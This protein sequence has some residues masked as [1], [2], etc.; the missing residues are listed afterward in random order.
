MSLVRAARVIANRRQSFLKEE[1]PEVLSCLQDITFSLP[2]NSSSSDGACHEAGIDVRPTGRDCDVEESVVSPVMRLS[3]AEDCCFHAFRAAS[4]G[5]ASTDCAT[6]RIGITTI[7]ALCGRV[8]QMTPTWYV[9][10]PLSARLFGSLFL[11]LTLQ[12]LFLQGVPCRS[13]GHPRPLHNQDE[14]Q[15]PPAATLT[16]QPSLSSPRDTAQFRQSSDN[17]GTDAIHGRR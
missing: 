7:S 5:K 10:L 17:G 16:W 13:Q 2:R 4:S 11:F 15:R 8:C 3:M 1:C 6:W 14:P 9:F 12:S